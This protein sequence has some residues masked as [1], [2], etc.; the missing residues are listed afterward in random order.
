MAKNSTLVRTSGLLLLALALLVLSA[1]MILSG[2]NPVLA[3]EPVDTTAP[4]CIAFVPVVGDARIKV[5][6]RDTESGLDSITVTNTRNIGGWDIPSF[7]S[8]YTFGVTSTFEVDVD[9]DNAR[10]QVRGTDVA[11][12]AT[13][14]TGDYV[15]P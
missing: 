6:L 11:G 15:G 8:G 9:S 14:C 13:N 12:N 4:G 3:G 5:T 2:T 7:P 10:A 1:L